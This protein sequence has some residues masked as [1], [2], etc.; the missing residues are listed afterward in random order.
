MNFPWSNDVDVCGRKNGRSDLETIARTN[1]ANFLRRNS[2]RGQGFSFVIRPR[3]VK[4][5]RVVVGKVLGRVLEQKNSRQQIEQPVIVISGS[6]GRD[7]N[8]NS[9]V[10]QLRFWQVPAREN[11]MVR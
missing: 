5:K 8:R 10:E 11:W 3:T 2:E 9:P 6:F 7:P 4:Q 1:V